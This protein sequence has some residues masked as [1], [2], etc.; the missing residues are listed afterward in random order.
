[1]IS[2]IGRTL[3][4]MGIALI[5][6]GAVLIFA[7]KLPWLGRLPGDICIKKE[8]FTFCFPLS[9]CIIASIV[10]SLIFM[11]LGRR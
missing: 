3:V 4:F 6:L 10:L 5:I 1:M 9:T 7:Q 8:N 11:F 2:G